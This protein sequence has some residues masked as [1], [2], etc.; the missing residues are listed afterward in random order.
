MMMRTLGIM[1]ATALLTALA[2]SAAW[3]FLYKRADSAAPQ[4]ESVQ[5][6]PAA[7]PTSPSMEIPL[8]DTPEDM[9]FTPSSPAVTELVEKQL[10]IPVLGY[11]VTELTPQFDDA[12]GNGRAHRALDFMA[13]RGTPVV[14]VDDGVLVKF[15]DSD[16]GGI[17]IYQFDPTET[18]VYYY[19]HLDTRAEG[20][21]EGESVRRGQ[22]IGTVGSTGNADDDA[23]HLHF[24]I[25]KLGPDKSWWKGEPVD[26]YPAFMTQ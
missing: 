11:D 7:S 20:I 23:P 6:A 22:V 17:T 14:A 9:V 4:A 24:A 18:W 3:L 10:A 2:T 16:R 8:G 1:L 21:A 12:R 13:E 5:A 25:E 15:F 26:P 19:A